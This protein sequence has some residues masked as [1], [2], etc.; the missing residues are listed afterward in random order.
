MRNDLDAEKRAI[1]RLW[2]KREM[3]IERVTSTMTN[4][5]GELQ[6]IAHEALPQLESIETLGLEG[7]ELDDD[8]VKS[9]K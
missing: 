8:I 7:S 1:Q 3:Q 6:G 2:S 4:V 5:V 9:I